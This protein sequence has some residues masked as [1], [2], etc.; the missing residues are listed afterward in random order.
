MVAIFEALGL[1]WGVCAAL[2]L[3]WLAWASRRRAP[4]AEPLDDPV[5]DAYERAAF[6]F[7]P[8]ITE[9]TGELLP[10]FT[11]AERERLRALAVEDAG[12]P[13]EHDELLVEIYT[14]QIRGRFPDIY[15]RS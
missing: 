9:D 14:A 1:L 10:T 13:A 5:D 7:G 3:G 15:G 11:A 8:D 12:R 4:A 6:A 2:T